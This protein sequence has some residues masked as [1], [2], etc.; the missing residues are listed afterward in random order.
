MDTDS[1]EAEDWPD[2]ASILMWAFLTAQVKVKG[3]IEAW[4]K[5][6][7]GKNLGTGQLV[8]CMNMA[9]RHEGGETFKLIKLVRLSVTLKVLKEQELLRVMAD[10]K[11]FS[12]DN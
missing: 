1:S 7:D 4:E 5:A 9:S 8:Q 12:L 11:V 10:I 2:K 6:V 3:N